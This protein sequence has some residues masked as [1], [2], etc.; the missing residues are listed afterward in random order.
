MWCLQRSLANRRSG[1]C[2]SR[3]LLARHACALG[4]RNAPAARGNRAGSSFGARSKPEFPYS[5]L[6]ISQDGVVIMEI[7]TFKNMYLAELQELMSV[8]AQLAEALPRMAEATSHP[9]L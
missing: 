8:E 2:G 6:R 3:S 4:S 1:T 9:A 5:R 7:K